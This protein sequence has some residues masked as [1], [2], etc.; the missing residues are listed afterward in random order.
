M[1]QLAAPLPDAAWQTEL[2]VHASQLAP[3]QPGLQDAHVDDAPFAH[4]PMPARARARHLRRAYAACSR[5]AALAEL[6][7]PGRN[8]AKVTL[9]A[10]LRIRLPRDLNYHSA[11]MLGT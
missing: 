10:T 11:L 8:L 3:C 6:G 2:C 9:H 7:Q 1:L 4:T 5:G